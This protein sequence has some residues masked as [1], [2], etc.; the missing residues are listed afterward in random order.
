[1]QA[2]A[3]KLSRI[4]FIFA[5]ALVV[6][7]ALLLNPLIFGV[8]G[9]TALC[10]RFLRA[11]NIEMHSPEAQY[12]SRS[13]LLSGIQIF[14]AGVVM[15][16]VLHRVGFSGVVRSASGFAFDAFILILLATLYVQTLPTL[17]E[18]SWSLHCLKGRAEDQIEPH[19]SRFIVRASATG[20]FVSAVL[21]GMAAFT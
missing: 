8:G 20:F 1:M 15:G 13:L 14:A 4:L 10:A 2:V 3:L 6:C 9:V 12:W 18:S 5:L 21:V 11:P 7:G 17:L 19:W 16:L